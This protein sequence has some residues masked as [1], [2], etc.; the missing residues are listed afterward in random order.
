[1]Q[2]MEYSDELIAEATGFAETDDAEIIEARETYKKLYDE[3]KVQ[4]EEDYNQSADDV[5]NGLM[6]GK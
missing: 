5:Y 3:F 4:T 1:M 6:L 2:K